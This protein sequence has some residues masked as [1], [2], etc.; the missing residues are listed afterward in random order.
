MKLI[1]TDGKKFYSF[2]LKPGKCAV[3]RKP[4]CDCYVPD[5]T[6]SRR[7]A[8]LEVLGDGERCFVTDLGSHNG[9][10]VNGVRIGGQVEVKCGDRLMFGDTEFRLTDSGEFISSTRKTAVTA[11]LAEKA[12]EKSMLMS[13]NEALRPLPSKVTDIPELFPTL[14][15]M[16]RMLVLHEPQEIMLQRA[17]ELVAQVIPAERLAVLFTRGD[18]GEIFPAATLLPG[19]KDP[20]SFNLSRTIVNDILKNKNTI[21]I[22]D[23]GADPRF[24]EQQSIIMS[25]MKSAMAV[26]LFDAGEVLGILYVD[27]TNRLH[28]YGDDYLR[29]LATFGNIIA[30]RIANYTLLQERQEK[31]LMQAELDKASAIQKSMLVEQFPEVPGYEVHAFQEQSRSVGGDLYDV[32]MLPDGRLL[33]MVADVSGKGMGAAL[34]MSNILAVFR[35]LYLSSGLDLAM[36]TKLV[37]Q[38]MYKYTS[39]EMFATLFIGLIDPIRHHMQFVNAG[40]NPPMVVRRDGTMAYLQPSGTMIGAF[41][42]GDWTEDIVDLYEG[43]VILAFTDGVTEAEKR[44]GEQYTEKR[45]EGFMAGVLDKTPREIASALLDDIVEFTEDA[46]QSDDI[47]MLIIK[48]DS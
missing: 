36:V 8:Q 1:G 26:P 2:E 6:V 45:L 14:S 37:S 25:E 10:M 38:Q 42:F 44:N 21:L 27:T 46:P 48:R 15:E 24:A 40:H 5:P 31:Q 4:D 28:R 9:T 35:I 43:D 18:Q 32:A 39:S 30:S 23:P 16:A 7:H 13:I 3:G 47:T 19:G 12:P 20:G 33:C 34:L 11:K 17:L 29:L 22:G 41:D